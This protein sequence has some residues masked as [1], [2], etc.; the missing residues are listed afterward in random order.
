VKELASFVVSLIST[1]GVD[2]TPAIIVSD[3]VSYGLERGRS[4]HVLRKSEN[5]PATCNHA[6]SPP[7]GMASGSF[8]D[9]LERALSF[10]F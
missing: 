7:S 6:R 3:G 5:E 2:Y 4:H 8:T 10:A 1:E 9:G